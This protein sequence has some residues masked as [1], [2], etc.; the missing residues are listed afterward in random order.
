VEENVSITELS[1]ERRSRQPIPRPNRVLP[2][3]YEVVT[4]RLNRRS[5]LLGKVVS[6][7]PYALGSLRFDEPFTAGGDTTCPR[8]YATGRL[9]GTGPRLHKYTRVEVEL[10]AWS[11]VACE[12]RLRPMTRRVPCWGKRRQRRYFRNAH[13]SADEM[14][15]WFDAAV[16]RKET[17]ILL[18]QRSVVDRRTDG[19]W[20]WVPV[21]DL[22]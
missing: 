7:V 2:A 3:D 19:T 6:S 14:V 8:W 21:G 18:E 17:T 9:Y 20:P 1:A 4:R 22:I 15:R 11:K 16:R 10:S 12:L 13:R 5:V